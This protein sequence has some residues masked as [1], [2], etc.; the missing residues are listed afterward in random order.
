MKSKSNGFIKVLKVIGLGLILFS[1]FLL[2]INKM[3]KSSDAYK[4][5]IEHIE[6]NQ[7]IINEVG[8][9]KDYGFMPTGKINT[10]NGYGTANIQIKVIGNNKNLNITTN[11]EK[12]PN[13]EWEM[14]KLFTD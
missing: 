8:G 9:I 3:M 7:E 10:K 4:V 6:K 5:S 11:L 2:F 14:I 12:T 13:G 1:S